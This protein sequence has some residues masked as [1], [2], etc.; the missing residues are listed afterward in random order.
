MSRMSFRFIFQEE[1]LSDSML[2]TDPF[3]TH[4]ANPDEAQ[5]SQRVQAVSEGKWRPTKKELP[6][7]L[8]LAH[9][10]PD[11]DGKDESLPPSVRSTGNLKVW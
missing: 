10:V 3:E 7:G 8:R 2:V 9:S 6:D 11:V 1:C 4:F 5:L